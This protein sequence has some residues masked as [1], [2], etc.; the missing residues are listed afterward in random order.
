MDDDGSRG[1]GLDK[2]LRRLVEALKFL[3]K[4]MMSDSEAV[5]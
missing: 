3:G 1:G 4:K 5:G 2:N